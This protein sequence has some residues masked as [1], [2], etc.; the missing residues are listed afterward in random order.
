VFDP[1]AREIVA[2]ALTAIRA[3]FGQTT[4]GGWSA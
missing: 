3:S 2:A 4:A 1:V